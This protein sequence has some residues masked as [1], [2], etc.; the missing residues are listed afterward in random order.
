MI[1][2]EMKIERLIAAA[3]KGA[4]FLRFGD[5]S[6]QSNALTPAR[7]TEGQTP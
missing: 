6:E 1:E 3:L 5:R 4:T 7:T 2:L